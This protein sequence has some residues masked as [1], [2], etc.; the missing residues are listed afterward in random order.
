MP[1]CRDNHITCI[2]LYLY[3]LYCIFIF[4]YD[5]LYTGYVP[6]ASFRRQSYYAYY[7]VYSIFLCHHLYTECAPLASFRQHSYYVY[8]TVFVYSILCIQYLVLSFIY[9]VCGSC[10]ISRTII[11]CITLY[12]HILYCILYYIVYSFFCIIIYIQGMHFSP[13]F[14][15]TQIMCIILY[16]H[17][18]YCIFNFL[19]YHL[20]TGYAPLTSLRRH[21]YYVYYTEFVYSAFHIQ[22]FV[23][24]SYTQHRVC[25]SR[26]IR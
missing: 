4:L 17:I 25:T 8:Y 24:H 16:L 10:L 2:L 1:H 11:T 9:R 5:H 14:D 22:Y 26:R 20:Y 23:Y 3:I 18:L 6:L 19:Y 12:V 21:S 13:H 7:T 15:D